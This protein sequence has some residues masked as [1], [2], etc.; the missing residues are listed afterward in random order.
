VHSH[1]APECVVA[2]IVG[3]EEA[4][5]LILVLQ[6]K[7]QIERRKMWGKDHMKEGKRVPLPTQLLPPEA[8][9]CGHVALSSLEGKF[10]GCGTHTGV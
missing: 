8:G 2:I 4:V 9:S 10:R 5:N 1:D 6:F 3:L 7:L